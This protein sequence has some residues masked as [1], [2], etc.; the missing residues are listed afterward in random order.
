MPGVIGSVLPTDV[1][2]TKPLEERLRMA[3]LQ[4]FLRK[5]GRKS[6]DL[7]HENDALVYPW[8][9][10]ARAPVRK[11][12]GSASRGAGQALLYFLSRDCKFRPRPNHT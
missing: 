9:R 4:G 1:A 11:V 5:R 8:T 2:I 3:V 7:V 12:L 10:N 6:S